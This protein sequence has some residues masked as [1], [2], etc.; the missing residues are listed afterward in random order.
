MKNPSTSHQNYSELSA[1]C[2]FMPRGASGPSPLL[3]RRSP[4]PSART[5][6]ASG[7]R[8]K[9]ERFGE[10]A[11][12]GPG[13]G[14]RRSNR[15]GPAARRCKRRSRRWTARWPRQSPHGHHDGRDADGRS[16]RRP[17]D[18]PQSS[19]RGRGQ[20]HQP[21]AG[22]GPDQHGRPNDQSDP[23]RRLADGC[24]GDSNHRQRA[25]TTDEQSGRHDHTGHGGRG[26]HPRSGR[27]DGLAGAAAGDRARSLRWSTQSNPWCSR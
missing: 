2:R 11:I 13:F 6:A 25:S 17:G 26:R 19:D 22:A 1:P 24:A 14:T 21:D 23:E 20:Q 27:R 16:D 5:P 10:E 9:D 15:S 4:S 3:R 8:T 18:E 12:P 7:T